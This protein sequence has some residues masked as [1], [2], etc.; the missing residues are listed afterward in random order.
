[1]TEHKQRN[2]CRHL[3]HLEEKTH[4]HTQARCTHTFIDIQ[5]LS[6]GE[7]TFKNEKEWQMQRIFGFIKEI[8]TQHG[9]WP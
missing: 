6:S 4:R 5:A 3:A 1:M 8:S 2:Y 9:V 7:F